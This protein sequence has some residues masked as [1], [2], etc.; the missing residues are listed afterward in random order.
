MVYGVDAV[1]NKNVMLVYSDG[2]TEGG[3]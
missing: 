2:R 3:K 1:P